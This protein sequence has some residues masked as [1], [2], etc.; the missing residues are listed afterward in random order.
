MHTY[1]GKDDD[2]ALI[3]LY[4]LCWPF[5]AALARWEEANEKRRRRRRRRRRSKR[6]RQ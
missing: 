3:G 2:G 1:K 6:S 4:A 5:A